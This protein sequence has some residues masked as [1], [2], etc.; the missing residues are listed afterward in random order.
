MSI[1]PHRLYQVLCDMT[2]V[3]KRNSRFQSSLNLSLLNTKGDRKYASAWSIF[4]IGYITFIGDSARGLTYPALWPLCESLGGSQV[5]LGW[6]VAAFS[7]GRMVISTELGSFADRYRHRL[8]LIL[9]SIILCIGA[10]LWANC[11][12]LGGLPMLYTGQFVM[13]LGTG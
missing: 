2:F 10:I 12:Y 3:S 11:V 13:G 7:L 5:D 1:Y 6:L 8:A 9:S 4:I